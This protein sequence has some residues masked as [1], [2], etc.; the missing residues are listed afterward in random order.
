MKRNIIF[1]GLIA[2]LCLVSCTTKKEEKEEEVKFTMT[3]AAVM[4]TIFNKEYIS[5][6]KSVRNIEIRAQEKGFLQNIYVDEGQFVNKGQ[7]LFRIM[8]GMYQAE[9]LK[10]SACSTVA[11]CAPAVAP[12]AGSA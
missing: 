9:L 2:M 6:I 5:Q 3:K 10:A 4:D 1:I 11:K 12:R 8:P 7:L